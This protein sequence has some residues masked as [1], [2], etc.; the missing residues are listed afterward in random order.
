MQ[1][2][3]AWVAKVVGVTDPGAIAIATGVL[4][5]LL[6]AGVA[7]GVLWTAAYVVTKLARDEIIH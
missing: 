3:V 2:F 4:F 5:A 1:V 7:K 6:V